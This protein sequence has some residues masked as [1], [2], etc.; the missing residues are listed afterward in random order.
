[1][2][3]FQFHDGTIKS[4]AA[5]LYGQGERC[6]NSTMVQ[7]KVNTFSRNEKAF[8]SFNSTMVQLKVCL[9]IFVEGAICRFNSTMVQLKGSVLIF[10]DAITPRFNSTM[11]QLKALPVYSYPVELVG[12]NSTM[13]QLKAGYFDEK[14]SLLCAFQF[15]DGTIKSQVVHRSNKD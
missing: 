5:R 13:V 12:F 6:F 4:I 8:E 3:Q 10:V 7:L 9:L 2:L 1:M 15:H 11:V 14:G